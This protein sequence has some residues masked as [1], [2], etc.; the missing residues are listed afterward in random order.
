M[1]TAAPVRE[2]LCFATYEVD[3]RAGELRKNGRR[4]KLQEQPFQILCL[5]LEHP[6]EVV[7]REELRQR[8]WPADTFVDFD[9]SLNTAVKK[10]RDTLGDSADNPRFIETIPKRGYR[11]IYP[12]NEGFHAAAPPRI[13]WPTVVPGAVAL[14]ALL[15][16]SIPGVRDRILGRRV[17]GKT[18]R[19]AVLPMKNLSGDPEQDYFAAGVTE[20]LITEL[21]RMSALQV[22]SHQSVLGYA[23]SSKPVPEIARELGV[24]AVLE[25]T[26]QRAGDRVRVTVNFVQAHPE[27][28]LL[29]ESYDKDARN[30]FNVQE[31]VARAIAGAIRVRLPESATSGSYQ[32]PIL[33]EASDAYLR[34]MYLLANGR[35]R[36]RDEAA[37]YFQRAIEIDSSF[38]RPYAALALMYAHGGAIRAGNAGGAGNITRQ[39][40]EKGLRLDDSL[41]EAHAALG[42]VSIYAWDFAAADR[43]FQRAIELN[44]SLALARAWYAQFLGAMGRYPEAFAQTEVALQ[45][46]P[47]SADVVSHAVEPYLQG[48]RVD[49]AISHWRRIT[50]LHPDYWAAHHFLALAYMKQGLH[51]KAVSEAEEA[52]SLSQRDFPTLAM[53]ASVYARA[54]ERQKALQVLQEFEARRPDRNSG[55]PAER[56]L[57]YAALGDNEK[58]LA[59]LEEAY[60]GR[61]ASLAFVNTRPQFDALRSDPRFKDLMRR[62]GLPKAKQ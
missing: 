62:V 4:V 42:W 59:L 47:G 12:I 29:A 6:G 18:L 26:V 39:W 30:I 45:L 15:A 9:D 38:G 24:D 16:F 10:L 22:T 44:P 43:E 19:V 55:R 53:L 35:D 8:L 14:I 32:R 23:Q 13:L 25:G 33:A 2:A 56:A 54:G 46:A 49:E 5:L 34:G 58:A 61:K 52:T 11:F 3:L 1:A 48:G 36:D 41:A 31:E 21:G 50:E 37:V 27:N 51:Q 40:A 20:M 17:P 7:T 57:V 28:H 60:R